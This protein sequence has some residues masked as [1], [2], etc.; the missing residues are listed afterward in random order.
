MHATYKNFLLYLGVIQNVGQVQVFQEAHIIS[1]QY[2]RTNFLN[3]TLQGYPLE[4]KSLQPRC[5]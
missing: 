3:V 4:M 1:V 5:L 2:H